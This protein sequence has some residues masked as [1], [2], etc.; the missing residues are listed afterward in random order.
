[1]R[2]QPPAGSETHRIADRLHSAAIHLLRGV[3]R[4]DRETGLS[5]QRLSALSVIVFAGPIPIGG[6]AEAEQVSAPTISRLVKGLER[7]GLVERLK[8]AKDTRVTRL[9]AT[10]AGRRLLEQGRRRRIERLVARLSLLSGKDRRLLDRAAELMERLASATSGT[11]T[12][13]PR[14]RT[15]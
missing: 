10:A 4:A 3:R 9:S 11:N 6:L 12:M 14:K 1:M 7:E 15:R 8:D 13:A 5:P 2:R